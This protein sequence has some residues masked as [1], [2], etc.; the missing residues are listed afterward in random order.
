MNTGVEYRKTLRYPLSANVDFSWE[1]KRR[2]HQKAQGITRDIGAGAA[3]IYSVISPSENAGIQIEVH[4][5]PL[6]EGAAPL[7]IY[8]QGRVSRIQK[9]VRD[10][11]HN[12][13]AVA[14]QNTVLRG[15]EDGA[16]ENREDQ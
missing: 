5:P 15:G 13:F 8:D 2:I 9:D 10:P 3:F 7:R 1:E 4:L 16:S 14:S 12:G 11:V 6:R